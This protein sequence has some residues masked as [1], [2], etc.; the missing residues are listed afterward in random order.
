MEKRP[1]YFLK[2][3]NKFLDVRIIPLLWRTRTPH[4]LRCYGIAMPE[5][6]FSDASYKA[7]ETAYKAS[8]PSSFFVPVL[9]LDSPPSER[10]VVFEYLQGVSFSEMPRNVLSATCWETWFD[11]LAQS[12]AWLSHIAGAPVMH[13]DIAPSNIMLL[14]DDQPVLVDFSSARLLDG[15]CPTPPTT[16]S[17]TLS[18]A[19]PEYL[20]ATPCPESDLFS[21][22]MTF[23]SVISGVPGK[24]LT[25]KRIQRELRGIES[26]LQAKLRSCL[27]A[28]PQ[29]RRTAVGSSWTL[30]VYDTF[31]TTKSD[32]G[33]TSVSLSQG[34]ILN[35]CAAKTTGDGKLIH[36][37]ADQSECVKIVHDDVYSRTDASR[38]CPFEASTCPFI[39]AAST[40]LSCNKASMLQ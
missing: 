1:P 23:L 29:M 30:L 14:S 26:P 37:P 33:L 24:R 28:D 36:E 4:L 5:E 11:R 17:G 34:N 8:D 6:D 2:P 27:S 12:L 35:D 16:F 20:T 3:L 13:G 22:A 31:S 10:M 15:L 40:L 9:E 32:D 19:A 18:Y 39:E 21:L 7:T 38:R 25:E